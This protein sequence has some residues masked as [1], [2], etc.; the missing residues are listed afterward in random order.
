MNI[1]IYIYIYIK[2]LKLFFSTSAVKGNF[3]N[4]KISLVGFKLP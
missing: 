1:Y 4:T 2:T 3:F